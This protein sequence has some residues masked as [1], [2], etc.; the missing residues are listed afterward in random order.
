[1]GANGVPV[2]QGAYA[3]IDDERVVDQLEVIG[4]VP[5]DLNG[6]HVRNGPNRRFESE[7]R[8]HWFDGDGMLHQVHFDRGHVS[9]RNRWV[10]TDPLREELAAGRALWRGVKEPPR[11]DRPDMPLKNTSNT[12]VKF[13]AGKL[14]S[15]W[16]LGGTVYESDPYTLETTGKLGGGT[17]P[18][19]I[20]AH[21]RV[22]EATG[23]FIFF[24]YGKEHPYMHYGVIGPDGKIKHQIPVELPGPR[25]PH[26][27][28]ITPNYSI[29]HD[30]PL[31]YDMEAFKAGR[32]KLKFYSELPSR[33]AVVP[34]FG[35]VKDIRWF[36]ADPCYM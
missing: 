26:D 15:M 5:A 18:L 1:M 12:D 6:M 22:D 16:Y 23:D 17:L 14:V 29:L 27:M 11:K 35:Q 19:P 36:E 2:L 9:Y 3:P 33:F 28:A 30:L 20:S 7:G 13:H 10:M 31:F 24:A 8:Y 21:S 34:R 4:E 25:L 32:H